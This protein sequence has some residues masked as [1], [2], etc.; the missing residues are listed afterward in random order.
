MLLD[1][2]IAGGLLVNKPTLIKIFRLWVSGEHQYETSALTQK[3]MSPLI[4][5]KSLV[6]SLLVS[7]H[8]LAQVS[9]RDVLTVL[10]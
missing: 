7:L 1:P 10:S 2:N 4:F 5:H 8:F 9:R 3:K 6:K